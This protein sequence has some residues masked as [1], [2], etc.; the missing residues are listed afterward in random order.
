ME[1]T[2]DTNITQTIYYNKQ[3][4]RKKYYSSFFMPRF[5]R[6]W[7][8]RTWVEA[9]TVH[10]DHE[11]E[12]MILCVCFYFVVGSYFLTYCTKV[13]IPSIHSHNSSIIILDFGNITITLLCY[14][15]KFFTAVKR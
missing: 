14:I 15:L 7:C 4:E 9:D 3:N 11:T 8:T 13:H 5:W 12:G 1:S 6:R 2:I 10:Y